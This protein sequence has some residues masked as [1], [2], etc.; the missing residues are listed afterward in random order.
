MVT[1]VTDA[2]K[3]MRLTSRGKESQTL[4]RM[5]EGI[6]RVEASAA[7]DGE[8]PDVSDVMEVVMGVCEDAGAVGDLVMTGLATIVTTETVAR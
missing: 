6:E 2:I 8:L 5:S 7:E 1:Y 4:D 3:A